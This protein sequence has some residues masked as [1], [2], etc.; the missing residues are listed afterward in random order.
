MMNLS[1]L[2]P[3]LALFLLAAVL[4]AVNSG[5]NKHKEGIKAGVQQLWNVLP[6]L[7]LAFIIAGMLEALIPEE[8]VREWLAREAGFSGVFLG[9]LGGMILAMGPYA[10]FPIIASIYGT[11]AGLGTVI[12]LVTAWTLL[13]LS[14]FPYESGILGFRFTL[15]RMS[16]SVPFCLAA[17]ATAHVLELAF[18]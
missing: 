3:T 11:G 1:M 2:V 12:S 7:I 4:I 9:T 5:K 8:F 16:I 15:L 10:S 17:G 14:K 6:M 18:F 13:S